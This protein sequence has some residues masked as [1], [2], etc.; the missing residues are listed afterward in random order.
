MNEHLQLTDYYIDKYLNNNINKTI[1]ECLNIIEEHQADYLTYFK[2]G[3]AYFMQGK[4]PR[5]NW[6]VTE[7]PLPGCW[8]NIKKK[9]PKAQPNG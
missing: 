6:T 4:N 9:K 3:F 5:R 7:K 1:R 8:Q 2:L